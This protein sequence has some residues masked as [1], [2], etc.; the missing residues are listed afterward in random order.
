MDILQLLMVVV[1]FVL[2][3]GVKGVT[4]MGL[5][6]RAVSVN[7]RTSMGRPRTCQSELHG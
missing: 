3:G 5:L 1:V 4:G 7:F 6:E 2:A